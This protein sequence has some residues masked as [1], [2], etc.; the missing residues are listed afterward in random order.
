M[1][2]SIQSRMLDPGPRAV[3]LW[4]LG[5]ALM[6]ALM[7]VVGGLT[8]LTGSGLSIMEW[9]PILG[10]LPPLGDAEWQRVFH[11][12]QHIAQY[13]REH[14]G[15]SL[16]QFK[17]IFW[18]E[19]THR[20]LGRLIG[21]VFLVP[22]LW[23]AWRG[24]IKRPQ[25]PRMIVLFLL[26]GLQGFVGWWMVE[27]GFEDR[28]SVSQYR[29]AIHLGVALILFVAILWTAFEYLRPTPTGARPAPQ[30]KWAQAFA[31]LVYVQMLLG[32]LVAGLHAGLVYNT[33]PSMDGA[34]APEGFLALKPWFLNVFENAGAA[35]FDHRMVAYAVFVA[36]CALWVLSRQTGRARASAGLLLAAVGLQILL[37]ILTLI[38]QV[39]I[40]LA[41]AHQAM[42]VVLLSAALWHAYRLR[43]AA[44]VEGNTA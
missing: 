42:A 36:A 38:D 26:G 8:R 41:A 17:G 32:S 3:G 2:T 27:S 23:F 12:Y 21:V 14:H 34:F 22:F 20:L 18:W 13:G 19:W 37:G 7:V 10:A 15:M 25:I 9:D 35:Q 43:S 33:W 5:V 39:P 11:L 16:A 30:A 28:V 29:L 24:A 40:P 6:I 44:G 31:G 4:L 1:T